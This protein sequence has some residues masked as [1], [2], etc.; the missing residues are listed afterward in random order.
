MNLT[1]EI[2][3]L[4]DTDRNVNLLNINRKSEMKTQQDGIE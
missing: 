4:V 1:M 3:Q 2:A